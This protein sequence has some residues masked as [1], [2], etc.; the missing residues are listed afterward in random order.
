V[1]PTGPKRN[2][3]QS[4]PSISCRP[5]CKKNTALGKLM[6]AFC[7]RQGVPMGALRFLF[8]GERIKENE[9]PAQVRP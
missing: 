5:Q 4:S 6:N 7:T 2:A 1:L 3:G 8:D 9:T